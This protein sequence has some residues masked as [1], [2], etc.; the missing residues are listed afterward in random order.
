LWEW[1]W[2]NPDMDKS[3]VKIIFIPGNGGA[4]IDAPDVWFPYLKIEFEKLGLEVVAR[5]FPDPIEAKASIWL[6]FLKNELQ[7]DENSILIGHSSGAVAAMR[8]AE[9]NKILGSV[10][11]GACYT[12]L[13]EETERIS[14]YFDHPWDW[15]A[16]NANQQWII[17]FSSTDDPFIPIE[18]PRF[19][20]E[21]LTTEYYEFTD[22]QHFGYP[23]PKTEFPEIVQMVKQKLMLI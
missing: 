10:L 22:Q 17:Q 14:G 19:I 13:G 4:R 20:H 18:E 21:K 11:V 9:Q 3:Q 8:Y 1:V 12:D 15:E 16:I 2:Y 23:N 7:A 5:N 6:P